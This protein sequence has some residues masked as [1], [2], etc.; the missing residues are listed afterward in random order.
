MAAPSDVP[1]GRKF[2]FQLPI[3]VSYMVVSADNFRIKKHFDVHSLQA[4]LEV[5]GDHLCASSEFVVS[6][7]SDV[8]AKCSLTEFNVL[9][10][11]SYDPAT[12]CL[13]EWEHTG[14]G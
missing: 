2:A 7:D 1:G 6:K 13:C 10:K 14:I 11:F 3:G 12:R 4:V 5:D 9:H 8:Y